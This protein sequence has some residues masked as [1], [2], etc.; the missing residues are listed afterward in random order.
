LPNKNMTDKLTMIPP[1]DREGSLDKLER[2]K[3]ASRQHIL[4]LFN[5]LNNQSFDIFRLESIVG[6]LLDKISEYNKS[7]CAK[8]EYGK[9]ADVMR[10][11]IQFRFSTFGL[12]LVET[13]EINSFRLFIVDSR[14][15]RPLFKE[16]FSDVLGR[17]ES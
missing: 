7:F 13:P 5:S 2:E 15:Q 12:A 14:G 8:D 17:L 16:S 3:L 10:V 9:I 1:K 4:N 11:T 6:V